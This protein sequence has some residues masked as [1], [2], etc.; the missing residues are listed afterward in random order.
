M[1]LFPASCSAPC[2]CWEKGSWPHVIVNPVSMESFHIVSL[3]WI[4][5]MHKKFYIYHHKPNL[6]SLVSNV[7]LTDKYDDLP[8]CLFLYAKW[9]DTYKVC[10]INRLH[11]FFYSSVYCLLIHAIPCRVS[12]RQCMSFWR[13]KIGHT[14]TDLGIAPNELESYQEG[15][16]TGTDPMERLKSVK[17]HLVSY[18]LDFMC[19]EDLRPVFNESEYY[20]SPQVFH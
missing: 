19:K 16:V 3:Y 1:G 8:R 5:V 7:S 17:G 4:C 13:V 2:L 6:T 9:S 18:P 10:R 12:L 15:D 14:T 20:A 11:L